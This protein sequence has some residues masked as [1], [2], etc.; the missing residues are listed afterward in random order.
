MPSSLCSLCQTAVCAAKRGCPLCHA[1]SSAYLMCCG[2]QV[3]LFW[4]FVAICTHFRTLVIPA[5][6]CSAMGICT[7]VGATLNTNAYAMWAETRGKGDDT[8]LR[9]WVDELLTGPGSGPSFRG[10]A[11]AC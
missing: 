7:I 9:E 6:V 10:A 11:L 2:M 8:S 5:V 4:F 1:A 3:W